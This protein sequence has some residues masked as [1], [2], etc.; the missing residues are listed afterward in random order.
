MA[1]A[2][3]PDCPVCGDKPKRGGL[4]QCQH[5]PAAACVACW[6]EHFL[7]KRGFACCFDV[8][9]D[10]PYTL[11]W[12]ATTFSQTFLKEYQ[13][14]RGEVLT[15]LAIA[16]LPAAQEYAEYILEKE[17]YDTKR[18]ETKHLAEKYGIIYTLAR[19]LL[20]TGVIIVDNKEYRYTKA[21]CRELRNTL[22]AAFGT[23]CATMLSNYAFI[24]FNAWLSQR[25]RKAAGA[26]AAASDEES[27]FT[28]DDDDAVAAADDDDAAA[29]DDDDAA[30]AADDD[31][32]AADDAAADEGRRRG[33]TTAKVEKESR[34]RAVDQTPL[35][36]NRACGIDGCRGFL[37]DSWTCPLCRRAT[38]SRCFAEV[39][40]AHTCNKEDLETAKALRAAA[41]PCP[42]CHVPI[43]K[44]EGCDQ[45]WCTQCHTAFSWSRG[46]IERGH[47]HNPHFVEWRTSQRLA[48]APEGEAVCIEPGAW[49]RDQSMIQMHIGIN[50]ET[51]MIKL[52][53]INTTFYLYAA[54]ERL[55][56]YYDA[57]RGQA[58]RLHRMWEPRH[59]EL[60]AN[61]LLKRITRAEL[62]RK[63][64]LANRK[65]CKHQ[66]IFAIHEA[67]Y[68]TFE[69]HVGQLSTR[70]ATPH[71]LRNR[72][73]E[74]FRKWLSEFLDIVNYYNNALLKLEKDLKLASEWYIAPFEKT[75][76]PHRWPGIY[77]LV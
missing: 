50:L 7:V 67:F 47:V 37:I 28:R 4:V 23:D 13:K 56:L 74:A 52:G 8:G 69:H 53:Y 31:A 5:C 54:L 34:P 76:H 71:H 64:E 72:E 63:L 75:W 35:K 30:A 43:V 40:G 29:A 51:V 19:S 3:K 39:T 15:E 2:A 24:D 46:E 73:I 14:K 59:V 36:V 1:A 66:E 11:H 6:K 77:A 22:P 17:E 18:S 61:Y 27:F 16:Q 33:Y 21:V 12:L 10:R 44:A 25:Q 20:A 62:A 65:Y 48:A 45:M 41:R 58:E 70:E 60:Q 38:C 49:L 68:T 57:H 42:N 9:C 26:A 55:W 32:A